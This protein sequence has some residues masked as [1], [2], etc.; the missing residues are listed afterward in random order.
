M[1]HLIDAQVFFVLQP[2]LDPE[3][4]PEALK[5]AVIDPEL[6]PTYHPGDMLWAKVGGH[7]FWACMVSHDPFEHLYFKQRGTS[8]Y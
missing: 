1:L 2:L 7:P 3:P 5:A 6:T 4:T 8:T